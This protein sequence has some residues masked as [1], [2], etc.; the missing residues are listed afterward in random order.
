MDRITDGRRCV[1]GAHLEWLREEPLDLTG[2][3]YRDLV[4]LRQFVHTQDSNNVLKGLVILKNL[5]YSTSY[6]VV[7]GT[8]DVRVHDTGG[9]VEGVHRWVDTF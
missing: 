6:A 5:L 4:F 9:R 8:D 7:L 2:T 3:G 1:T